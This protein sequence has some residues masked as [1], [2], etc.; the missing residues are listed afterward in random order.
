MNK[1]DIIYIDWNLYSILKDPKL[2]PHLILKD[3]L[4]QNSDSFELVYSDAH[5]GDLA[6]TDENKENQR[7]LDLQYLSR[8]TNDQCIVKYFGRNNVEIDNRNPVEFFN[9]NKADNQSAILAPFV[10]ISKQMTD[11]YGPTR[12]DI[13]R[14]HFNTDPKN[15]CNFSVLQ[16]DEL[17]R[18]IGISKSLE[19]FLEL[20][21][22]LRGD[23]R[24]N[25]ITNIDYY[26]TAYMNLD[27]IG[28]YP[29]SMKA[30]GDFNNLLNDS[31]H[32]AYGS[33][34]KAF[35]TNDNK[36][37]LKS[38]LLFEYFESQSTLIR[39]CKLKNNMDEFK[40]SLKSLV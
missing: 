36:C 18:K 10:K 38:K 5:L 19:D 3:F 11:M 31:K 27:L 16:L 39:T 33:L 37:Y 34:C 25:P 21:L 28:F 30:K 8:I 15:I 13:I 24:N 29:D 14:V 2:E 17:V 7:I 35:I 6:K 1:K 32:S 4:Q 9:T 26:T 23:T 40:E 20:G 12:D 22:S